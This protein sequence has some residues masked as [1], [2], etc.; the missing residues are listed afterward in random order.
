MI[1]PGTQQVLCPV[2]RWAQLGILHIRCV[3]MTLQAR[4][5]EGLW[6]E[7]QQWLLPIELP[8]STSQFF[9]WFALQSS[10]VTKANKLP[11]LSVLDDQCPDMQP[12]RKPAISFS[13]DNLPSLSA[14]QM[15][16]RRHNSQSCNHVV[17]GPIVV[18]AV[19]TRETSPP[20]LAGCD[21][22]VNVLHL[23]ELAWF[24]TKIIE[25]LYHPLKHYRHWSEY[26]FSDHFKH[27]VTTHQKLGKCFICK[28]K[29]F[30]KSQLQAH[31]QQYHPISMNEELLPDGILPAAGRD[32]PEPARFD[33]SWCT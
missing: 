7:Q 23:P 21:V 22:A 1:S 11:A 6:V 33:I 10:I 17:S 2:G 3:C 30:N 8:A 24:Q 29:L 13:Y 15:L 28:R 20:H 27:M 9:L 32:Q 5:I 19:I 4:S 14:A 31:F 25:A 18:I 12:G 16:E 26:V